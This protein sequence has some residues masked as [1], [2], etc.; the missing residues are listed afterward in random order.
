MGIRSSNNQKAQLC[1][2]NLHWIYQSLP[3]GLLH[4]GTGQVT[5]E[6]TMP[7]SGCLTIS[8]LPLFS[9]NS[10]TTTIIHVIQLP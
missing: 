7:W 9:L 10:I 5:V 1:C 3:S 6:L 2:Q 8:S 4:H